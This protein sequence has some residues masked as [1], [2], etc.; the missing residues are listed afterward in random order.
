M[1]ICV[2][3]YISMY[4]C[5]VWYGMVWHGM[6]WYGMVWYVSM[7]LCIY[8][9]MYLCIYVSMYLCIYVS[10]YLCIYVSMYV[11]IL[12]VYAYEKVRY[13]IILGCIITFYITIHHI[14]LC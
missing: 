10:M 4:V 1:Y 14:M 5:M 9:S 11:C 8:V 6:V 3:I 13:Y 12:Y 2:Y 7:Y